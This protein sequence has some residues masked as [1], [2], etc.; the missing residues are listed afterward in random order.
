MKFIMS[1]P[2]E[3]SPLLKLFSSSHS[4]WILRPLVVVVAFFLPQ[5]IILTCV[6]LF[7]VRPVFVVHK[8]YLLKMYWFN[9]LIYNIT[10]YCWESSCTHN[11]KHLQEF[12]SFFHMD[13]H[14]LAVCRKFVTVDLNKCRSYCE[15]HSGRAS[16][17]PIW[18]TLSFTFS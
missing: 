18:I 6:I 11:S 14:F 9:K 3:S 15:S 12:T 16:K 2:C 17:V 10:I 7:Y 5:H 4:T 13:I 1:N 8:S